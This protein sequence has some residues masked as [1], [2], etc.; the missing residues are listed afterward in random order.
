MRNWGFGSVCVS[1]FCLGDGFAGS[2][3][4]FWVQGL[5][6]ALLLVQV[7]L[8]LKPARASVSHVYPPAVSELHKVLVSLLFLCKYH[9]WIS[10]NPRL[11][12]FQSFNYSLEYS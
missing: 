4:H 2:Y 8:L 1:N 6:H 3:M 10:S 12:F 9:N 5:S 11:T 7:T